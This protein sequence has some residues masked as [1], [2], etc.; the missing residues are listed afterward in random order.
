[1]A[2]VSSITGVRV[3]T[4]GSTRSAFNGTERTAAAPAPRARIVMGVGNQSLVDLGLDKFMDK[5]RVTDDKSKSAIVNEVYKMVFANAYIMDSEKAEM[6]KAESMFLNG[7]LTVKQFV[8]ALAM[9]EQYKK[10]FFDNRPVCGAVEMNY[11]HFLGRT[12]DGLADYQTK[13]YK[14]DNNGYAAFVSS[15]FEDGEYDRVFGDWGVPYYRGYK[16]EANLSMTSFTHFF[17]VVRGG[18]TSDK[19]MVNNLIPLNKNGLKSVPIP[20]KPLAGGASSSVPGADMIT[21]VVSGLI[22]IAIAFLVIANG[23]TPTS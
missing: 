1:M 6:N 21:T 20:V 17:Q 2:F 12:P 8:M 9:T 19:G 16:S 13:T 5:P 4:R 11:K 15:F 7:D 18:S 3:S 22:I 10:R 23:S 14:Y